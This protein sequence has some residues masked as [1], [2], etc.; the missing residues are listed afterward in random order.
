MNYSISH[1]LKHLWCN[2]EIKGI[3]RLFASLL[4]ILRIFSI[5]YFIRR[6]LPESNSQK[7]WVGL[8][9]IEVYCILELMVLIFI[10]IIRF[11]PIV[12]SVIAGYILFEI[13][14]A[15]LNIIFIG[16]FKEINDPPSSIERSLILLL[17]NVFHV[18]LAFTIFYHYCL[19][20]I[21]IEALF[22]AVLVLGTVGYPE[23]A[24]GWPSLLIALQIFLNLILILLIL[25]S[26]IGQ[27]KVFQG[28][29]KNGNLKINDK[30]KGQDHES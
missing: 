10:L 30:G 22:K 17:M 20:L 24:K 11:G 26:F 16:K 19:D 9:I 14:T 7:Y 12:D 28:N 25:G 27:L 3:E 8:S 6:F 21:V 15:L 23:Q 5:L 4:L 13:Y 2:S 1:S 29:Q 18:V